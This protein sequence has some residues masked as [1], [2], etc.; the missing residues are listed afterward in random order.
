MICRSSDPT[1]WFPVAAEGSDDVVEAS[2][3]L[4]LSIAVLLLLSPG[5]PC[6]EPVGEC[7][8]ATVGGPVVNP[9]LL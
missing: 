3:L 7:V 6:A 2:M 9:L 4:L 8:V 5:S 1:F